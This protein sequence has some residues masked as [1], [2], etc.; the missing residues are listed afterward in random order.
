LQQERAMTAHFP[1]LAQLLEH[2][3]EKVQRVVEAFYR[4]ASKDLSRLEQAA[5]ACEW[6]AVRGM[7]HRLH[8]SCLHVGEREAATA[9]ATLACIPGEFFAELYHRRRSLIVDALDRAEEFISGASPECKS[10][11]D[12]P[13]AGVVGTP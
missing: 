7:A 8:V 12:P 1:E 2:D 11:S 6:Q 9:A 13:D 10:S 5:V 3:R 4:S